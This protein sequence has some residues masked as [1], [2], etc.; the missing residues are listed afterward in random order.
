MENQRHDQNDG[1][2]RVENGERERRAAGRGHEGSAGAVAHRV[3]RRL[4]AFLALKWDAATA[5]PNAEET[6]VRG[7]R[8]GLPDDERAALRDAYRASVA[9][10]EERLR[11]RLTSW[12]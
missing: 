11:R 12:R 9:E 4:L 6:R 5:A 7:A 1:Q 3:G 10:L 2:Q 8:L